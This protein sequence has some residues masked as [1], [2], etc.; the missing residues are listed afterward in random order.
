MNNGKKRIS[1]RQNKA[2]GMRCGI[3]G[4]VEVWLNKLKDLYDSRVISREK[5]EEK[6]RKILEEL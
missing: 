5:Y 4:G 1:Y 2:G 6:R 3:I